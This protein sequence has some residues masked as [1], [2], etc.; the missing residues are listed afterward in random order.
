[1][2]VE[3]VSSC[4]NQ[5]VCLNCVTID[6]PECTA[7][8]TESSTA[9]QCLEKVGSAALASF[10]Q[11]GMCKVYASPNCTAINSVHPN[12]QFVYNS[13]VASP[14]CATSEYTGTLEADTSSVFKQAMLYTP[15]L[16]EYVFKLEPTF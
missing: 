8:V 4:T 12:A 14:T 15:V 10:D 2:I 13:W 1:V 6:T 3:T 7:D 5:R 11:H 9:E 16:F